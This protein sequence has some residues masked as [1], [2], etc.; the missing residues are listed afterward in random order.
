MGKFS[1]CFIM[2]TYEKHVLLGI[3]E[4]IQAI[5]YSITF[6]VWKVQVFYKWLDFENMEV[7]I[8]KGNILFSNWTGL[9]KTSCSKCLFLELVT[10]NKKT[11]AY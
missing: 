9:I 3:L 8:T 1:K 2:Y 4:M 6:W 7:Q 10:C 11:R 5:L